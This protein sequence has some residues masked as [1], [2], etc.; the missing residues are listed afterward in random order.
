MSKKKLP[1]LANPPDGQPQPTTPA[2]A[3]QPAYPAAY[4]AAQPVAYPAAQP[5]AAG[6]APPPSAAPYAA[7]QPVAAPAPGYPGPGYPAPG[8][9]APSYPT[10]GYAAPGYP[11]PAYPAPQGYG[12]PAYPPP[13]PGYPAPAY[14]APQGYAAAAPAYPT[15]AYPAAP[16]YPAA[17]AYPA[18]P[19]PVPTPVPMP[20]YG[21][22]VPAVA[23]PVAP[24]PIPVVPQP[25]AAPTPV[26]VA[27]APTMPVVPVAPAAPVIPTAKVEPVVKP[28][29]KVAP[30]PAP[31]PA[32]V[33]TPA[34]K[35]LA[36]PAGAV[37]P[38]PVR[39]VTAN[40]PQVVATASAAPV[41][42]IKDESEESL[43]ERL[44]E[45]SPPWL[46]S[47]IIHAV[48]LVVMGILGI[49]V[50]T[51]ESNVI[52]IE[53]IYA[54]ELGVQLQDDTLTNG[55]MQNIEVAE[56]TL[57][58]DELRADDPF[59]APPEVEVNL[60]GTTQTST[61]QAPSI[62]MALTGREKGA[63]EALLGKYGGTATTEASVRA[64]L[65]WLK[66][67]QEPSGAWSLTGRYSA[68][69]TIENR[70]SATAMALLAFQGAGHTHKD[71]DFKKEVA[72]GW[73]ALLKMQDKDGLFYHE[74]VHNQMLYSQAQATIAICELYGMTKDK[75]YKEPAER[76]I[77]YAVEA[78][79]PEGGWRYMPRQDSDTSVTGWYV[80]A[81][82]SALMAGL[83]V[84]SPTLENITR[85]LDS[86]AA[87]DGSRY[88]YRT[89]NDTS[90]TMTAEGLLC[91]QYLGWKQN[92]PRMVRGVDLLLSN[93]IRWD[94]DNTNVYYWY[95]ATQVTHHMEGDAW[96]KWNSVMRET[97]PRNQVKTGAEAG[98]WPPDTD[99]WGHIGGRLYTTCLSI[100]M[101]EVY[102]RHLP[103]YKWRQER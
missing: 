83:D 23:A 60:E 29:V 87:D 80:M 76:A 49:V 56:P 93:P 33:P 28:A 75:Q 18:A 65:E 103:I 92:D 86:V 5:V 64:G 7:V 35:P 11:A 81:L 62:G 24:A 4:P 3:S 37:R 77:K 19:T 1:W 69:S 47:A 14:P 22:V 97:I 73:A 101:L 89:A 2:P 54:E 84:P 63:K 74:G 95:Y 71:G 44:V 52:T 96:K 39:V 42:Q 6:Y 61:I 45:G 21:S 90:E 10:P 46:I 68:G 15:P 70:C 59:A 34:G 36:A 72:K 41:V 40:M 55:L 57:S 17:P 53:P 67:N 99:R 50:Q 91:R 13:T 79:S 98:S 51:R 38:Q 16:T 32:A 94:F 27:P 43:E 25:V 85:F 100:Y 20:G 30:A 88:G 26:R 48:I 31:T 58:K 78:Q 9:Q 8:Y 66:R 12:A 102:Y 82:Q